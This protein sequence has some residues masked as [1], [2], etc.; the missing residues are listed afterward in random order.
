MVDEV[1]EFGFKMA[2]H[3]HNGELESIGFLF[4]LPFVSSENTFTGPGETEID[5]ISKTLGGWTS[6]HLFRR[7]HTA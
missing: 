5:F 6:T 7:H 2:R 1:P 4:F 3:Y